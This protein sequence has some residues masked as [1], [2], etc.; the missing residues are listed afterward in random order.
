[1]NKGLIEI[2]S[3]E[4][5]KLELNKVLLQQ[6]QWHDEFELRRDEFAQSERHWLWQKGFWLFMAGAA[7]ATLFFKVL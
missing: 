6:Q 1:M 7:M 5:L 3:S 4:E 2:M